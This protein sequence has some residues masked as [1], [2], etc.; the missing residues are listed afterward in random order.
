[1]RSLTTSTIDS[2][3]DP[4]R[5]SFAALRDP[6]Y[7]GY[8]FS[9]A[10]A[11]MADSIEHVI[12]YWV[13]FQKFHSPALGGFAVV[14]HWVP[15]L[16]FSL[17]AGALADRFNPRRLI[18]IGMVLFMLVSISWGVLFLTDRLEMWHAIVLLTLHGFAGVLWNPPSQVLIHDIVDPLLLPSAVRLN[19]TS[20]YLG[21][22]MGPG[23]G[24]AILW[25]FGPAYGILANALLY[26]PTIFWL[27]NAPSRKQKG[28]ASASRPGALRGFADIRA[29][30]R[31]IAANPTLVSMIA[32]GG[33]ASFFVGN[34][35]QAQMP[36]FATDL[37]HGHADASYSA[38]LAADAAGAL[39]A[40]VV[41]ESRGLLPP[42]PR[43]AFIL[44]MMWCAALI[45]FALSHGYAL[46]LVLLFIAG[47]VELSFSAMAQTLVQLNAPAE[48][49][50]RV[51]G[52]F[53]MSSLGLRAFSG[54]TVGFMGS[55]IGPRAS[56]AA[57]AA[58]LLT[59]AFSLFSV[60]RHATA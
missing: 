26:L 18:Q 28:L 17:F 47:F 36:G 32:L 41:L 21:L 20:R 58:V 22:L 1:V 4:S 33:A 16:F 7:R 31:Q 27:Q 12:S 42:H 59:I 14:S 45:A 52:V 50:G 56:L 37:G 38:L 54:L 48:I 60:R 43:T 13:I 15:F 57:S 3:G 49:R 34:S 5:R 39:I 40:G 44:A 35:Y 8:F 6:G 30:L 11:M 51:I 46:A 53:S 9:M 2:A 25:A 10:G 55:L 23:I 24:A 19:A 29:T